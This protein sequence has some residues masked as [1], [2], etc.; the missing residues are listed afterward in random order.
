ML[1]RAGHQKD[2]T[3][4]RCLDLIQFSVSPP[5]LFSRE[6]R[7]AGDKVSDQSCLGGWSLHKN[8]QITGFRGLLGGWTHGGDGRALC[9]DT[10]WKSLSPFPTPCPGHLFHLAVPDL[11]PFITNWWSSKCNGSLSFVSCS[12]KWIEPEGGV[13]G[14]PSL[15]QVS[16]KQR[17]QPGLV[18]GSGVE[19]GCLVWWSP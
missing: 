3:P 1:G 5:P 11:D 10:L 2:Q 17:V 4:I 9:L 16:Q 15:E 13:F 18:F 14:S 6:G 19:G 8:N 12:N 7:R